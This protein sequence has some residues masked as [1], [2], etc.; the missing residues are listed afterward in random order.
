MGTTKAIAAIL[1]FALAGL[2]MS[3]CSG[4]QP[5]SQQVDSTPTKLDGSQSQEFEAD[6]IEA[7]GSAS[8]AVQDYCDG[9]VSEAQRVGCLS[10]VDESD[11]P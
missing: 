1:L 5:E 2:A 7:A 4:A 10:H 3:A 11:I 8:Q 9:A 6:D